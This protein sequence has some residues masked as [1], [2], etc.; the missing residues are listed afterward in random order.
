[1]QR[2]LICIATFICYSVNTIYAQTT[3]TG[4]VSAEW[5]NAAN[6]SAGLPT[7]TSNVTIP[8]AARYPEINAA[9]AVAKS[10]V[11]QGGAMLIL[12]NAGR[13]TIR[14]AVAGALHNLGVV[15]NKGTISIDNLK[16]SGTDAVVNEG[17]FNNQAGAF[18]YIDGIRSQGWGLFAGIYN[19]PAGTFNNAG[20]LSIG[21]NRS[22][23]EFGIRNAG[24]FNNDDGGDIF[25]G[26]GYKALDNAGTFNNEARLSFQSRDGDFILVCITNSGQFNNLNKGQVNIDRYVNAAIDISAGSVNNAGVFSI[27]NQ[28]DDVLLQTSGAGKFKNLVGGIFNGS[29]KLPNGGFLHE[30]GTLSPMG[31]DGVITIN[32]G[33]HFANAVIGI[34]VNGSGVAEKISSSGMITL[35]GTLA[36]DIQY[37]GVAGDRFIIIQATTN[38]S[39]RFKNVTGLPS[40]WKLLYTPNSVELVY[41]TNGNFWTG[42]TS[43]DWNDAGNWTNGIPNGNSDVYISRR[44]RQPLIQGTTVTVKSV[45]INE[46]AQLSLGNTAHLHIN[47]ATTA[48]LLNRGVL[49]IEGRITIGDLATIGDYGILNEGDMVAHPGSTISIDGAGTRALENAFG[50]FINE[51]QLII[52][53]KK[54]TGQVGIYN[55]AVFNNRPGAQITI[56]NTSNYGIEMLQNSR[57]DNDGI[58]SIGGTT[59]AGS[60][61]I[62]NRGV[63][64][65]TAVGQIHLDRLSF[66]GVVNTAGSFTNEGS[67]SIGSIEMSGALATG[68]NN[69][70]LFNNKKGQ[71]Y[72]NRVQS[73]VYTANGAIDNSGRIT[74]G[75]L[76]AVA[77]FNSRSGS[78]H[79][80]N[81]TGG[82][83]AYTGIIRPEGFLHNG[84]TVLMGEAV[85]RITYN[86]QEDEDFTNSILAI[87]VNGN[88]I[89]S[90]FDQ[91]YFIVRATLGGTLHL[92]FNYA[93]INGE[94]LQIINAAY[95]ITGRFSSVTGLPSHWSVAYEEHAVY[96]V[97][98]S[99]ADGKNHWRGTV[100][101]SWNEPGNWSDGIPDA[102]DDV[103]IAE[104]ND[105][106]TV[107]AADAVAKSVTI[108]SGGML[109]ISSAGVLTVNGAASQGILNE[110]ILHNNGA[111]Q[112]GNISGTGASA[113]K[114]TGSF[115]NNL[116]AT[117]RLDRS[118]GTAL[119][120]V[121]NQFTNA[122]NIII[123]GSY[124]SGVDGL[125]NTGAFTNSATGRIYIDRV[126]TAGIYNNGAQFVNH[127]AIYIG[128][129]SAGNTITWGIYNDKVFTHV[130]G[131][132]QIDRV[133]SAIA[134]A[135]QSFN[136]YDSVIIGTNTTVPVMIATQGSGSFVNKAEGILTGAGTIDPARFLAEGGRL[137]PGIPVGLVTFTGNNNFG[138]T[139]LAMDVN[140]VEENSNLFDQVVV[141]RTATLG[142]TLDLVIN[143]MPTGGDVITL[144]RA[145]AVQGSFATVN[146]LASNWNIEY[147]ATAVLLKYSGAARIISTW[148]GAVSDDWNT[149]GNWTAAVPS[150][151]TDAIIPAISRFPIITT[152][153]AVARAITIEA[154][155]ALRVAA[156]ARLS[157]NGA[158]DQA[159]LNRGTITNFG[160]IMIGNLSGI[161][162]YGI[163]N[164]GAFYNH[165]G[166]LL[167]VDR[168]SE[169]AIN[170]QGEM[171][172][173]SLVNIGAVNNGAVMKLG[174]INANLFR[175]WSGTINIDRVETGIEAALGTFENQAIISI[176]ALTPAPALVSGTWGYFLNAATASSLNGSGTINAE[177][178]VSYAATLAPGFPVGKITFTGNE[179]LRQAQLAI[180]ITGAGVAGIDYDQVVVNGNV[181]IDGLL[182]LAFSYG[183]KQGDVLT[184][185]SATAVTGTFKTING[186]PANWELQYSNNA[187]QLVCTRDAV[188]H[189]WT[190]ELDNEWNNPANWK[191]NAVPATV[192]KVIFP[193]GVVNNE[194]LLNSNVSVITLEVAEGRTLTVNAPA[195]LTV[196]ATLTNDGVIKGTGALRNAHI[197]NT[198]VLS[199]GNS[200][201]N[202]TVHGNFTNQGTI[203]AE[204]G[205]NMPGTQ[206]DQLIVNGA[207]TIG[208]HL[209]VSTINGYN[210]VAGQAFN[211]VT[212]NVVSGSFASVVLPEGVTGS[213]SYTG[214]TVTLHILNVLPLRLLEFSA[215]HENSA[216]MLHWKTAQ[217]ENTAA[218]EVQR[219]SDGA[220]FATISVLKA[221][222]RGAH[223]YS[224]PDDK[225]AAGPNY[226]RLKMKDLDGSYTYSDVI[227]VNYQGYTG[228]RIAP[229]PASDYITVTVNSRLPEGAR[230]Q[231]FSLNGVLL[232]EVVLTATTRI[233][234]SN[235]PAGIYILRTKSGSH[236]FMKQ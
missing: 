114:N 200:A 100:S 2:L 182:T 58:V 218:F 174:I 186:L 54:A 173:R 179:D 144:L 181:S 234:V 202:L 136:S 235:Y 134:V 123:G 204:I 229:V 191:N 209:V 158:E 72:I 9:N 18:L 105:A 180:D 95:P 160:S 53:A 39:G 19:L 48:A 169:A 40:Y 199:P 119:Y 6:W 141:E 81:N 5:Q 130:E 165:A 131:R 196:T 78:G 217:E 126:T 222:G 36:L 147:T 156:N 194:L 221:M 195:V 215:R 76:V 15:H 188:T 110:G 106:P 133:Q 108:I 62:R 124:A 226:Y 47:G 128:A 192:D 154:G 171:H 16:G 33:T 66:A 23:G 208:G 29:G 189:E 37:P 109:R 32:G 112:V 63:F 90:T 214:G 178:F 227:A 49:E 98:N 148:T 198:G 175:N 193:A 113:I 211:L 220:S 21:A 183:G 26:S 205:G 163:F 52:G 64:L 197:I 117:L 97:C 185:L 206:Y 92:Q 116:G 94:R 71:L 27:I 162:R 125:D 91:F 213:I 43:T 161:G 225:P 135:A 14:E 59:A 103:V 44:N 50:S 35:D 230:A 55:T 28:P 56:N 146:G 167:Q 150:A 232:A 24:S 233:N 42:S 4:N 166:S 17:V 210:L 121:S 142:G 86:G 107:S 118:T 168:A 38:L 155:G 207:V 159:I 34:D 13:L 149:A 31:A 61:G 46:A 143:Y 129:L 164:E 111:I 212:G 120:N 30:G 22:M 51:G 140:G 82:T 11:V 89:A 184:I 187:V 127:G 170:N 25:I 122:G 177:W 73:A 20:Q 67:V 115:N 138:D 57:F 7:E 203:A 102:G 137:L 80:S 85:G 8:Q 216:V 69:A 145:T 104:A 172:N 3:W 10:L 88:Q 68:I 236:R 219:S 65:N 87:K 83:L 96:L 157:I 152:T 101:D 74:V 151:A 75:N 139:R 84:G 77:E 153:N 99:T 223:T 231:V 190:G 41:D 79:F 1:M 45:T 93:G 70:A 224:A 12:N 201:G 228:L 60:E 176:G 132:I